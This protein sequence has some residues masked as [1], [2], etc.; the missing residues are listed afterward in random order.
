[1]DLGSSESEVD[2]CMALCIV[3]RMNLHP[4]YSLEHLSEESGFTVRVIRSWIQRGL[5]PAPDGRGRGAHYV[6]EHLDRLLFIRE[7]QKATASKNVPHEV[8]REVFKS[9]YEGPDPA[10]VHRVAMGEEELQIAGLGGLYFGEAVDP[11][12][13]AA[14]GSSGEQSATHNSPKRPSRRRTSRQPRE[15]D[16]PW[17]TIEIE[18]GLE[19]RLR[20]DDPERV[21]WLARLARHLRERIHDES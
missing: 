19:L 3:E 14:Q 15:L 2:M 18:D 1:M 4:T 9:L 12:S 5:L 17:T 13:T 16:L 6:Q 11:E 20:G 7:F 8:L 21:A 10:V